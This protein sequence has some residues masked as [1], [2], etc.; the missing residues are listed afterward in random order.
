MDA[1]SLLAP[2]A[3][4]PA[5]SALVFDVDGTLAPIVDRPELARVPDETRAELRRLAGRY[6]LVACL[7]GRP[8]EQ[9][10]RLVGVEGIRYVGN[11][12]L[13]L[14]PRGAE[15]AAEIARFRAQVGGLWPVEDKRLS[16]SLHFREAADET[17]AR[18]AL[19]EIAKRA[20]SEGL[21]ARWGRK[22]LEIR[23]RAG[24]DKG[25]AVAALAR[26]AGA[27]L[28]LYAGDD[29]TDL[30]AF[31]GLSEAGL[32]Y[33]VRI[34]VASSE[35]APALLAAADLVVPGPAALRLLLE[36]L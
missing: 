19:E 5:R 34:A 4:A 3:A 10:E 12:G 33:A 32:A 22:V 21:D 24:G 26:E 23:P 1:A 14:D 13:E 15:I 18:A 31:R 7:S 20:R 28:G 16:L 35:A 17:A 9:A 25:T 6:L 2:L 11:H 36:L 30:D 29:A 8:G 27:E